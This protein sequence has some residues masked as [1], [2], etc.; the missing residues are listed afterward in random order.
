MLGIQIEVYLLY[1]IWKN[2]NFRVNAAR[3]Y[4]IKPQQ[5]KLWKNGIIAE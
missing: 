4:C 5:N 3:N 1:I 2:K